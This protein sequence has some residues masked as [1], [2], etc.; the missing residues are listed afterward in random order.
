MSSE[1][2]FYRYSGGNN[3]VTFVINEYAG[4]NYDCITHKLFNEALKTA[5]KID[6]DGI[7]RNAQLI[8][9]ADNRALG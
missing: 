2:I 5:E 9:E 6:R 8:T 3:D 7:L 4:G 1:G